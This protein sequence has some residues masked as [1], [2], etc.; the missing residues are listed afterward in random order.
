M[1]DNCR[2]ALSIRNPIADDIFFQA[3]AFHE[4]LGQAFDNNQEVLISEMTNDGSV[5]C[6]LNLVAAQEVLSP[7]FQLTQAILKPAQSEF[8]Y[9][10]PAKTRGKSY[11][12]GKLN[13]G[14][15]VSKTS[16]FQRDALLIPSDDRPSRKQ[17][18]YHTWISL[19]NQ[20]DEERLNAFK[21][22]V[23]GHIHI[24]PGILMKQLLGACGGALTEREL[25]VILESLETDGLINTHMPCVR[26]IAGVVDRQK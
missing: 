1:D 17:G 26:G 24:R 19:N 21:Q 8:K 6:I 18:E 13:F 11:D 15:I 12:K 20:V 10:K 3:H 23:L 5:Y 25:E 14:V 2:W 7:Y 4:Y 9:P 16:N 22:L